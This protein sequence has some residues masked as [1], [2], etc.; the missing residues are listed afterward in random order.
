[1]V[2]IGWWTTMLLLLVVVVVVRASWCKTVRWHGRIFSTQTHRG[3]CVE[4]VDTASCTDCPTTV[5]WLL[6]LMLVPRIHLSANLPRMTMALWRWLYYR[7]D[8]RKGGRFRV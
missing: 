6:L 3:R 5:R 4:H 1:M 2:I 8:T 7:L